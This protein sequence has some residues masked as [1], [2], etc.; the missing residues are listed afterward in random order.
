MIAHA[1]LVLYVKVFSDGP[2]AAG[3]KIENLPTLKFELGKATF[4]FDGCWHFDVTVTNVADG[5]RTE[6]GI[7]VDLR[8]IAATG[9]FGATSGGMKLRISAD[10]EANGYGSSIQDQVRFTVT[11]GRG[12]DG[13]D[14]ES[15]TPEPANPLTEWKARL[16]LRGDVSSPNASGPLNTAGIHLPLRR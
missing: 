9:Q 4:H 6:S 8:N 3:K 11:T 1:N 15:L 16:I 14:G 10:I 7:K 12:N 5:S 13:A 2:V